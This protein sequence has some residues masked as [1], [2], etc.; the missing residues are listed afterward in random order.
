VPATFTI[1]SGG[2]VSPT[3]VSVPAGYRVQLTFINKGSSPTSVIVLTPDALHLT[4]P[5]GG[6]TSQI[7]SGLKKGSYAIVIGAAD[8]AALVIG[9]APGP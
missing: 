9:S 1:S 8:R 7:V 2:T 5:A 6:D 3:Q 4:V